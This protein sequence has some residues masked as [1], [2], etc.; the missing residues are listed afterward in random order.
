MKIPDMKNGNAFWSV[1]P[2]GPRVLVVMI[3]SGLAPLDTFKWLLTDVIFQS[4]R[5]WKQEELGVKEDCF[6]IRR[7]TRIRRSGQPGIRNPITCS[8]YKYNNWLRVCKFFKTNR[9]IYLTRW[10]QTVKYCLESLN[11]SFHKQTLE[12]TCR[13]IWPPVYYFVAYV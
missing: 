10:Q 5:N 8:P 4:T 9:R 2:L 7:L 3:I 12:D 6:K 1:T 13:L 11:Y